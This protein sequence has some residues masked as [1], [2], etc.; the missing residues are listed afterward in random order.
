MIDNTWM[1]CDARTATVGCSRIEV[2]R[3]GGWESGIF[4][5]SLISRRQ[6]RSVEVIPEEGAYIKRTIVRAPLLQALFLRIQSIT[7]AAG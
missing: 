7:Q 4:V 1:L 2:A 3:R 6:I 5:H